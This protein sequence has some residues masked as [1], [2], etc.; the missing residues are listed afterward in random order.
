MI[1]PDRYITYYPKE[2][3]YKLRGLSGEEL[4][5]KVGPIS[6]CL[7]ITRRCNWLCYHCSENQIIEPVSEKEFK[8]V[9][10]RLKRGGVRKILISGGEPMIQSSFWPIIEYARR[11]F[12]QVHLATNGSLV[13]E[14]EVKRLKELVDEVRLSLYGLK[15]RHEGVTR[16]P[17]SFKA[18]MGAIERLKKEG[19]R[20]RV[21]MVIMRS[22]KGELAKVMKLL[23]DLGVDKL[24]LFTLHDRG[25][26]RLLYANEYQE[27][28]DVFLKP[29][30][31]RVRVSRWNQ[32]GISMV[33]YP[34][35]EMHLLPY[36]KNQS[37]SFKVGN[38]LEVNDWLGKW[39]KVPK[40]LRLNYWN[41]RLK[42]LFLNMVE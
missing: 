7:Q 31:I 4:I 3:C 40:R 20:V 18:V 13:K 1:R 25:R 12:P 9:M 21:T 37:R 29:T 35:G 16:I 24:V 8:L 30:K 14:D 33:V 11:V 41:Y 22:N 15:D 2:D 10:E 42:R 36:F 39:F 28:E 38:L 26:A 27:I 17:G 6:V 23:E 32:E 19:V 5:N 34:N